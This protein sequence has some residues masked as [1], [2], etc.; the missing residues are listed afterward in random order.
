MKKFVLRFKSLTKD[1]STLVDWTISAK[2]IKG[3][4]MDW[5]IDCQMCPEKCS[6]ICENAN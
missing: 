2:D 5:V 1:D 3:A 4:E 6:L